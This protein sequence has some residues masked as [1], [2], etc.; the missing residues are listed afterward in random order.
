MAWSGGY[1]V[2]LFLALSA[3]LIT[4][5]LLREKVATGS[6]DLRR[7]YIRRILRIIWPLY[8]FYLLVR[9]DRGNLVRIIST[10]RAEV[11]L[12][13]CALLSGNIANAL[14]GWTPTFVVSHIWTIAIEEQFYL[15][16]PLVVRRLKPRGIVIAQR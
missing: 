6:I 5:L 16:W 1:S 14:W 3:F 15:I 12:I 9:R 10:L 8:Y 2:D 7:F 11:P 4:Q 13:L